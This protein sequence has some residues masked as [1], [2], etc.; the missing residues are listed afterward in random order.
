MIKV[1]VTKTLVTDDN[2]KFY[3]GQ[4]ISFKYYGKLY[5][6]DIKKIHRKKGY[7]S[8]VNV[9]CDNKSVAPRNFYFADM[10]N[11]GYVYCD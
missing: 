6:C 10:E 11:V 1:N 9:L 5:I 3:E 7:I 2:K 4:D 8:G